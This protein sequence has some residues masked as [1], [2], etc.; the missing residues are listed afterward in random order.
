MSD[1]FA[2]FIVA[3]GGLIAAGGLW[4][5]VLALGRTGSEEPTRS[6]AIPGADLVA[7]VG[8]SLWILLPGAMPRA[9]AFVIGIGGVVGSSYLRL[10]KARK[11][12]PASGPP[13]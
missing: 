6:R 10:V 7:G 12:N 3:I 1:P 9:L 13:G 4:R 5:L 2:V 8:L 11:R